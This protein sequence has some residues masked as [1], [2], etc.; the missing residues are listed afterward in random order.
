MSG[1]RESPTRLG[2]RGA[3]ARCGGPGQ[4]GTGSQDGGGQLAD[5]ALDC[6]VFEQGAAYVVLSENRS[7]Q[8]AKKAAKRNSCPQDSTLSRRAIV[9]SRA[10][11]E[12]RDVADNASLLY[13]PLEASAMRRCGERDKGKRVSRRNAG[14]RARRRRL[15]PCARV[16][17]VK[18]LLVLL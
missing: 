13:T 18:T 14:Y 1:R 5:D 3:K 2:A 8:R 12:R 17:V 4:N 16:G 11:Y 10:S 9:S 6:F 15:T 7:E